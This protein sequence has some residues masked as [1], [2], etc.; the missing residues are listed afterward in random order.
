MAHINSI[1]VGMF[2]D[3]AIAMPATDPVF[4]NLDTDAEFNALFATEIESGGGTKAAGTFV[5]V[6]DVREFPA[7]GTPPNLTNVPTYGRRTALQVQAQADAPS[8]EITLNYVPSN[9]ASGT[10]LGDSV[11]SG[12]LFAMR[13]SLLNTEP[14][15]SGATKFASDAA[16]IGTVQNSVY[17]WVGKVESLLVNPQL[18]DAN[19]ATVGFSLQS[20]FFGA[21][22][23]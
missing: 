5:R 2:S 3:L 20:D 22:T 13:F 7:L 23:L 16:G 12:K 10:L 18:N 21:Y 14:T 8:M 19:T 11:G 1:G 15:G 9:W 4:A 17:Y 6:K